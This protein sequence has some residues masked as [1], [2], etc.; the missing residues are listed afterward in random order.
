MKRIINNDR[1]ERIYRS[2]GKVHVPRLCGGRMTTNVFRRNIDPANKADMCVLL[3]ADESASMRSQNKSI[4]AMHCAVCLAEVLSRLHI[5]LKVIGFTADT[6]GYH[7]VHNHYMHWLNTR[8]ERL[9]LTS[10]THRANNFDGYSIRYATEMLKNAPKNTSCSLCSVMVS[11]LLI[12]T[13]EDKALR[14]RLMP[15]SAPKRK[16]T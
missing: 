9:Y 10:I 15:L 2:C 1:G 4:C 13:G 11:L 16:L 7:V 6:G 5:P 8:E 12:I 14:I 3:L